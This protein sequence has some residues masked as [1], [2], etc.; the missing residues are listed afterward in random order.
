[1]STKTRQ[2]NKEKGFLMSMSLKKYKE[3]QK[4]I[5]CENY[6]TEKAAVPSKDGTFI[7]EI[8]GK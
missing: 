8:T 2:E 4:H 6:T 1:L 5:F 3:R 7:Q